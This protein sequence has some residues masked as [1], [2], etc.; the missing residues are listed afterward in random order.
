MATQREHKGITSR[1]FAYSGK[2]IPFFRV[3][4]SDE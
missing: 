3:F 2:G 4:E 1:C